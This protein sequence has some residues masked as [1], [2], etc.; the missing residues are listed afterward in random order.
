MVKERRGK[1]GVPVK[2]RPGKG[3]AS[4]A[5]PMWLRVLRGCLMTLNV[6]AVAMLL[7]TGYAGC[8]SPLQH[9]AVWGVF[10]LGFPI[11]LGAVFLLLLAECF[12]YLRGALVL[13][14]GMVLCAGPILTYF[15]LNIFSPKAPE[16]SEKFSLITYN[17]HNMWLSDTTGVS[18]NTSLDYVLAQNADIVCLQESSVLTPSVRLHITDR[19]IEEMHAAYPHVLI[20]G[21]TEALLSKYPV[22]AIHI[23][24]TKENF[25]GG[26]VAAYRITLPSGR[27]ISVFNV[28]LCSFGLVA[29]DREL[30]YNLTDLKKEPLEEVKEQLYDKMTLAARN[31]AREVQ[32]LLRWIRLYGGPD[33]IVCGDFNDVGGCYAIRALAD[34]GFTDVY[35]EI[36]FGPM[37][38]YNQGRFYFCIDHVLCRG[39]LKPLAMRKGRV[40]SSDH[41]PLFTEF[42][43]KPYTP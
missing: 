4:K 15:P 41:Y 23:A 1:R 7:L 22:E 37:V 21:A 31:R 5:R 30:Y 40:K 11:V 33:A 3:K 28:H 8:V 26:T 27:L 14:A 19:Q 29:A 32:Q 36:G 35:P 2:G 38:T 34:A 18:R 9:S 42:A 39:A 20:T 17:V 13:G 24:P 25:P 16:G 10:P 43:L 12:F 6:V